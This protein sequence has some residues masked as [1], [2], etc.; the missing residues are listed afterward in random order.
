MKITDIDEL[1][2]RERS[3]VPVLIAED[4]VLLNKLIVDSLKKAGYQ[5][6]IHT[7]NGQ[8][9]YDVIETC[10]KEGTLKDHVQCIITDIEMPLMDGHR[11][12][13]LVKDYFLLT[14]K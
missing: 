7:K 14:G 2:E 10:K 5:N 8:E 3:D 4:S 1:G 9:A 6:L 11:L 13:K 12:T